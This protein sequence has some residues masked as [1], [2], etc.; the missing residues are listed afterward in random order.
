MSWFRY[1]EGALDDPKVQRLP[2]ELF[3]SW[4]NLLCLAKRHHGILP[5]VSD[6]AFALRRSEEIT[7]KTISQLIKAGLVDDLEIGLQPHNWNERQFQSDVSTSRVK[8]FRERRATVTE[9]PSESDTE[10]EQST[11]QNREDIGAN[12]PHSSQADRQGDQLKPGFAE[13]ITLKPNETNDR[14]RF[15][16][17]QPITPR[18]ETGIPASPMPAG[19]G[20]QEAECP[21]GHHAE[22]TNGS[23]GATMGVGPEV[24]TGRAGDLLAPAPA[25][26]PSGGN[27]KARRSSNDASG[28]RLPIDW[29]PGPA[30][31]AFAVEHQHD[32][33]EVAPRFCDYWHGVAGAKGRKADWPATWRNW[34][35]RDNT[36]GA[37][38]RGR[39]NGHAQPRSKIDLIE[40]VA[41]AFERMEAKNGY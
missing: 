9:T 21:G 36:G 17:D 12:A 22:Q 10:S 5:P 3:K 39:G 26:G 23:D 41:Q 16:G 20:R 2:G 31:R 29:Q 37:A 30:E 18:P 13:P 34:I 4:V 8:R 28:S 24:L 40:D 1:Y 27:G 11:E 32:P 7:K 35:R 6:I 38:L 33:D 25:G 14:H 19:F 15:D